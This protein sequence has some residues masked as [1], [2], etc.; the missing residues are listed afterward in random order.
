MTINLEGNPCAGEFHKIGVSNE[1]A[2]SYDYQFLMRYA[3]VSGNS[4]YS[5]Y[6]IALWSWDKVNTPIYASPE[7]LND[8]LLE[9]AG[10]DP[11]AA[12]WMLAS[13]GMAIH[14]MGDDTFA[15]G[16]ADLI[17]ADL[18]PETGEGSLVGDYM[19]QAECLEFLSELD[20][21][22][23]DATIDN[24]I[25]A[26]VNGQQSDGC[27]N[28]GYSGTFQDTVY[29]TRA[30]AMYGGIDGLNA[31]RKGAAW[32]I[33]QQLSNGGWTSG[34]AKEYSDL[35]AGGLRA[36]VATEAPVTIDTN[37]Y[38]SIQ[39]AI[40]AATAGDTINVAAGTYN[41]R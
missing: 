35:D 40:D 4:N 12:S 24:I 8:E 13:Y 5:D 37:G 41:D 10:S 9:W 32:L 19:A 20:P 14:L 26:L 16:C 1:K 22:A 33:P 28:D 27:W 7:A 39:S 15:T 17:A 21:V 29:S 38:Y 11:G 3:A 30:L 2:G 18:D 25:I 23:Y 34:V 31:A 6:A 36:L